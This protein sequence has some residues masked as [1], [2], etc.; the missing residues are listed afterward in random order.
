[1]VLP[2]IKG[3]NSHVSHSI[4]HTKDNKKLIFDR[5]KESLH[6]TGKKSQ[7]SLDSSK[8]TE[9]PEKVSQVKKEQNEKKQKRRLL[10]FKFS[11][12]GSKKASSVKWDL[13]KSEKSPEK[14]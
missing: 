6:E 1:M 12:V 10:E 7:S 4:R 8:N 9:N 3:K 2:D 5:S 13:L 11:E 14:T